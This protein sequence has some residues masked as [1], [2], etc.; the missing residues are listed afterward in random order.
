MSEFDL[1][2]AGRAIADSGLTDAVRREGDTQRNRSDG[3]QPQAERREEPR[4]VPNREERRQQREGR[5]PVD[6]HSADG[7]DDLDDDHDFGDGDTFGGEDGEDQDTD[8]SNPDQEDDVGED[9]GADADGQGDDQPS[10]PEH[11]VTVNGQKFKVP[12][13][14]LVA[15]YQRQKDYAQKTQA[16]ANTRRDFQAHHV[17]AAQSYE[18]RNRMLVGTMKALEH[19]L[20]GSFD[21]PAMAALKESDPNKW[22]VMREDIN[23]RIAKTRSFLNALY[24]DQERHETERQKH[25]Q[26]ELAAFY[27]VEMA[28]LKELVPDWQDENG[29]PKAALEVGRFLEQSG[30]TPEEYQAVIDHRMLSIAWKAMRYDQ[31][32]KE[33]KA[34]R[35]VPKQLPRQH[36]PGKGAMQPQRQGGQPVNRNA[37]ARDKAKA[38]KSGDMRDAA[39]ALMHTLR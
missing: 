17:Q 9:D 1:H 4:R 3:R 15:G 8:A 11:E 37:F 31:L 20:V 35:Q 38:A 14:E 16:L 25:Q 39:R 32:V 24:T 36:K 5:A 2:S 7:L 12:L 19:A 33:R 34:P 26:A 13:S 22:L 18:Q 10:D 27:P 30:F 6:D 21:T 23:D 29:E 28:K